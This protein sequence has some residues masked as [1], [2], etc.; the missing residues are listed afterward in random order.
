[1]TRTSNG[2]KSSRG[3]ANSGYSAASSKKAISSTG[4]SANTFSGSKI[5]KKVESSGE[6]SGILRIVSGPEVVKP[7][8][9]DTACI[10]YHCDDDDRDEIFLRS[11]LAFRFAPTRNFNF[12]SADTDDYDI[13]ERA[14]IQ[15]LCR[16]EEKK[17][18][19]NDDAYT[20]VVTAIELPSEAVHMAASPGGDRVAVV[21]ADGSVLCYDIMVI[22]DS[23]SEGDKDNE[24]KGIFV[25]V[26]PRWSVPF[27]VTATKLRGKS[28][29]STRHCG[30]IRTFEV[31]PHWNNKT[32]YVQYS[33]Q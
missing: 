22:Y 23:D 11:R 2:S 14:W 19:K 25:S 13:D 28:M 4:Y 33:K 27:M 18:Y 20:T 31:R 26:V 10:N 1:M 12:N 24:N 3:S 7:S 21:L 15:V 8:G 16:S 17:D 6:P 30:P 32:Q 29:S 9:I 5:K